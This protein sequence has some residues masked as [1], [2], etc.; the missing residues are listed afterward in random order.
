MDATQGLGSRS[1]AEHRL[2]GFQASSR[3]LLGGDEQDTSKT[4]VSEHHKNSSPFKYVE[5]GA[6]QHAPSPHLSP[7]QRGYLGVECTGI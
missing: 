6:F 7:S 2:R 4:V 1:N 3:T 5:W